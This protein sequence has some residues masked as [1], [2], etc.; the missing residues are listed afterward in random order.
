MEHK[1]GD[2][3][4][5]QGREDST[6]NQG[7]SGAPGQQVGYFGEERQGVKIAERT[8]HEVTVG[9]KAFPEEPGVK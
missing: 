2:Q 1:E 4:Y 7:E 9:D 6:C 3:G 5:A 8:R